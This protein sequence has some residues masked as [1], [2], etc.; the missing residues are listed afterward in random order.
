MMVRQMN[1]IKEE[2]SISNRIVYATIGA[3]D[4]VHIG[5]QHLIRSMVKQANQDL[6]SSLVVT[7]HPHPVV[8]LRSLPLPFYISTPSEKDF[9]FRQ[10]GVDF[11]L[12]LKF[13]QKMASMDPVEFM[14]MLIKQ[15]PISQLWL[16]KDFTLGKNRVGNLTVL[17]EIGK[18]K[19]FSVIDCPFI[20]DDYGKVSSSE[21]RKWII[22]GLFPPTT[23][24]LN[25]YYSLTGKVIHGDSRGRKIGFPTANL[26]VWSG[27]LIPTAGV[28][29]TW[30]SVDDQ[31]FHSVT[32]VGLRPTFESTDTIPKIEAYILNFDQDI[33][34]KQVQL[35]F[36][37]IIR[38][39]KKFNS[40][41]ELVSQIQRDAKQ[42]EEILKNAT[43]PTGLFT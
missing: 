1:H 37:E 11:V 21:I 26:D 8:L 27:K 22:A 4:G 2:K 13:T 17:S 32:N 42:A 9:I 24:A 10:L 14:D 33:Y 19:G 25:R 28:Y 38:I 3:F 16:G 43:K 30:I 29:A 34:N 31:I 20:E 41:E 7:F 35:H 18:G 5:H 40:I 39:E 36:V 23:R 6:A 12:D 15:Y